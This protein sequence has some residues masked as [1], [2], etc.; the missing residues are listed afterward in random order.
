MIIQYLRKLGG[1]LDNNVP[2]LTRVIASSPYWHMRLPPP[3]VIQRGETMDITN[4]IQN[5]GFP[6]ACV[7][8]LAYYTYT[9]NRANREENNKR[10]ERLYQIIDTQSTQLAEV[11]TQMAEVR[12]SIDNLNDTLKRKGVIS[13]EN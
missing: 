11:S 5:T 9:T 3:C 13:C 8:M 4:L 1:T 6:I 12:T 2:P 7:V 10:E